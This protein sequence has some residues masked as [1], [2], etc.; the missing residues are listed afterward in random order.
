[1][2]P[3]SPILRALWM[4]EVL[5]SIVAF[6]DGT[7]EEFVPFVVAYDNT[8]L[9]LRYDD[10]PAFLLLLATSGVRGLRWVHR[11]RADYMSIEVPEYVAA[12]GNI[13]ALRYV[14]DEAAMPL[15]DLVLAA[16]AEQGHLAMLRAILDL[17]P[18]LDC[19]KALNLAAENGH[20]H[21]VAYLVETLGVDGSAYALERAARH[22]YI[23]IVR[24]LVSAKGIR[25]RDCKT[26]MEYAWRFQHTHV[27][28]LLHERALVPYP[29]PPS[30]TDVALPIAAVAAM[31]VLA[32]LFA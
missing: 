22:G 6:Q 19:T 13:D 8:S 14:H 24:M 20:G 2:V 11:H 23:A 17:C 21:I 25:P 7:P 4:P 10:R 30:R 5:R 27:M 28:D 31:T 12:S 16:A 26:A 32:W 9:C 29:P 18:D 15:T 1:M 3:T